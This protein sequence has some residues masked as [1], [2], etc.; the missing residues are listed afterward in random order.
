MDRT[1]LKLIRALWLALIC[2]TATINY[3]VGDDWPQWGGLHRDFRWNEPRLFA[4]FPANGPKVVWR[5]KVDS[6]YAGP[7][8]AGG[9]V[10]VMDYVVRA[11]DPAVNAGKRNELQGTE[12]VLC[13]DAADGKPLWTHEYDRPYRISYPEGPRCTPA[14]D[15]ELVYTLGAEGNLC[16]LAV[17]D[18]NVVWQRDLKSDYKMTEAPIWGFAAHPLVH[19]E[20]LYCVVGGE[21]SVAVA[22]NKNDGKEVWRSMSAKEPG[23]CPPTI[24]NNNGVEQLI[25]WHAES[26]NGLDPKTGKVLWSNQLTPSY[27]MAIAAPA[28]DGDFL[29]ASALGASVLLK[30]DSADG[31]AAEIWHGKGFNSS[32]SPII[33]EQGYAFGVDRTG[34]LRCIDLKT[35]E[36]KWQTTE[37]AV[38][39]RPTN[40]GTAFIVKSGDRFLIAGETGELTIARMTPEKYEKICSAKILEPTHDSFDHKALWSCPAYANGCMYWRNDNELVCVSLTA[41]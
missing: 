17:A 8:V 24:W 18:G 27:A 16:C 10:F 14:V 5:A 41:E 22:F 9:K 7:A 38:G 32:H 21:G 4:S 12:R 36:R 3:V 15:G 37:P 35:G 34:W 1:T 11:G 26:I 19:G 6:G 39:E 23:Y 25:I 33:A 13:F 2:T 20:L 30:G 31:S 40:P 28:S 29:F